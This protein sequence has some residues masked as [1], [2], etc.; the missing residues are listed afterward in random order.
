MTR[1]ERLPASDG[2]L[3]NCELVP[4]EVLASVPMPVRAAVLEGRTIGAAMR[5]N[6]EAA[7]VALSLELEY[8]AKAY[9]GATRTDELVFDELVLFVVKQYGML[10]TAEI[11]EAFRLGAAGELGEVRMTAYYGAFTVL[12]LGDLLGAY[13]ARREADVRKARRA[14]TAAEDAA[15]SERNRQILE[16]SAVQWQDD[17]I[18][19][20]L[21]VRNS[22]FVV[23]VTAYDYEF[24]TARGEIVLDKE[25]K[26]DL[27]RRAGEKVCDELRLEMVTASAFRRGEIQAQIAAFED[28]EPTADFVARQKSTA[29]RLAVLDWIAARKG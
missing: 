10:N 18:K 11:R 6:R 19:T 8:C 20:L 2:S 23:Y 9:T 1:I 13:M 14:E 24:L 26:W 27:M 25:A 21:S 4:A 3:A 7:L 22:A 15:R 16:A 5:E 12:M 29:Q 17:R 28:G